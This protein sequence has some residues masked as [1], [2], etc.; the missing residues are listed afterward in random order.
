MLISEMLV[1]TKADTL[2]VQQTLNGALGELNMTRANLID[3]LASRGVAYEP[4]HLSRNLKRAQRLKA[5]T[6]LQFVDATLECARAQ[7]RL[8]YVRR[9]EGLRFWT[10]QGTGAVFR[11]AH[12]TGNSVS[13]EDMLRV[14]T[15]PSHCSTLYYLRSSIAERAGIVS[16][17]D[18]G[19]R[20]RDINA[21]DAQSAQRVNA[22][23]LERKVQL[24]S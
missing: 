20:S 14:V 4:T 19:E 9:P 18:P 13:W 5:T 24:G 12:C 2:V 22:F 8:L 17:A 23:L 16:V 10:F 15:T 6:A 11:P 3:A 21:A 7:S 1:L